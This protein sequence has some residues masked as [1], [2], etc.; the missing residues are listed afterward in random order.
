[1]RSVL[2]ATT[3][4][5]TSQ[6]KVKT[7]EGD[8]G[9]PP[10]LVASVCSSEDLRVEQDDDRPTTTQN[11]A[12]DTTT[13]IEEVPH[14]CGLMI[15][16]LHHEEFIDDEDSTSPLS[17]AT[18][19]SSSSFYSIS[20]DTQVKDRHYPHIHPNCYAPAALQDVNLLYGGGSGTAV[21][22]GYH[23]AHQQSI[24]M[25]HGSA[26]DTKEVLALVTIAQE[27]DRRCRHGNNA[28]AAARDMKRRIPEFRYVYISRAHIRDRQSELWA[29]RRSQRLQMS[30]Q[31]AS[32][33]RS[34]G[35]QRES[36]FF[37]SALSSRSL[38]QNSVFFSPSS[39]PQSP[40]PLEHRHAWVASP[41]SPGAAQRHRRLRIIAYQGD[42][43][44]KA[45]SSAETDDDEE[46]TDME[47][48]V[49]FNGVDIPIPAEFLAHHHRTVPTDEIAQFFHAFGQEL[50]RQEE[51]HNWK[52]TLGQKWIGGSCRGPQARNGADELTSGQLS[53]PL[54]ETLIQG[55]LAV[56]RDLE[57][58]TGPEER[59]GDPLP[60]PADI[61]D[62][63]PRMDAFCGKC[64]RKN[65]HP[66]LGRFAALRW[67]CHDMADQEEEGNDAMPSTSQHHRFF[68]NDAEQVPARFLGRLFHPDHACRMDDVFLEPPASVVPLDAVERTGWWD[69]VQ[70]AMEF[71]PASVATDCIWTC[72]LTDAGLHNTFVSQERGLELF[73]LGEPGLEP[74]PAFLTKFLMSFFH[75][76]GMESDC[77]TS[78]KQRFHVVDR[79][80]DGNERL[81]LTDETKEK[82]SYLRDVFTITLDRIME[83]IFLNNPR[84]RSLMTKYVVLQLLSDAA[85]CL[86]RWEAKG[87]G[88]PRLGERVNDPLEKWLWRSLWDLYIASYVHTFLLVEEEK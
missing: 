32:S 11:H 14:G 12:P 5:P 42:D 13:L 73:D 78:W 55:I 45:P 64:L 33:R 46:G 57:Q 53:G 35:I 77:G 20:I 59:R 38:L 63:T 54:L 16:L 1:M 83:E 19:N 71:G 67:I 80:D 29:T 34:S 27:L 69:I 76:L 47:W 6:K 74:R 88:E 60:V 65:F 4:S 79:R 9:P 81:A 58:L 15:Q 3:K 30:T 43:A 41:P 49:G 21:F 70:H 23:P 26:K 7:Q 8:E 44:N 62:V 82:I 75:T 28:A 25:K 61:H 39:T 40:P 84:I 52:V 2:V 51:Q 37:L 36:P 10:P 48:H 18:C 24:V 85:F 31:P 87:G 66:T 17:S 68:L 56:L 86:Q 22:G 72:G 50:C